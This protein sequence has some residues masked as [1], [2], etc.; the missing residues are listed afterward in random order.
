MKELAL[1]HK[2][3]GKKGLRRRRNDFERGKEGKEKA[4]HR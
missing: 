1:K 4:Q 3:V 2:E